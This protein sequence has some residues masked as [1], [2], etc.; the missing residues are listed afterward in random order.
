[1]YICAQDKVSVLTPKTHKSD[2]KITPQQ[3][4]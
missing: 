3:V 4:S 1:M 2:L